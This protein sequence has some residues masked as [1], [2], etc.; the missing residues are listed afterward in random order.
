MA[1]NI[2]PID[3]PITFSLVNLNR[4]ILPHE[5][6]LVFTLMLN[7]FNVHMILINLSSFIDFL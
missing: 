5:E 4:I 7:D 2:R 6:A 1:K 3:G